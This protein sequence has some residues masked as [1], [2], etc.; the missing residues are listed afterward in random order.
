[1]RTQASLALTAAVLICTCGICSADSID[2][3]TAFD[4][5]SWQGFAHEDSSPFKGSVN[6]TATNNGTEAWGD[7]HFEIFSPYGYDLSNIDFVVDAGYEPTSSQAPLSWIVDNSLPASTLGLYFY[8]D[9]VAVGETA[10][11]TVYTDN[12]VDQVPNFGVIVYPSPVPEPATI[13]LLGLGSLLI[14]RKK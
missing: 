9:P 8:G 2:I 12:T 7:F 6:V 11:F 1:M 10:T 5:W 4:G 14:H 3:I 13:A